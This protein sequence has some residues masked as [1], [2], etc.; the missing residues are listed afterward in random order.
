MNEKQFN[1]SAF[2]D[3]LCSNISHTAFHSSFHP[4][5]F[6]AVSD[7]NHMA[8]WKYVQSRVNPPFRRAAENPTAAAAAPDDNTVGEGGDAG[9]G[10]A[11]PRQTPWPPPEPN[12][13]VGLPCGVHPAQFAVKALYA[14]TLDRGAAGLAT[15]TSDAQ[16]GWVNMLKQGATM[17]MEMWTADEKP[18]L[19]WSHP[20]AS[21]L[22]YLVAWYLFGMQPTSPGMKTM[23]I[24]PAVGTLAHGRYVLPTV[25][26]RVTA[27]FTQTVGR[28]TLGVSLPPTIAADDRLP[29][30]IDI[31]AEGVVTA[32][33]AVNGQPPQRYVVEAGYVSVGTVS[34]GVHSFAISL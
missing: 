30:P 14:N 5:A 1:G 18:N 7:A 9:A 29:L 3:G 8:T 28:F 33:V 6:G 21:S 27:S 34:G 2:C 23:R 25:R 4:L 17:T 24:M 31:E 22:A 13:G 20:W 19:T 26:G 15:L 32:L 12:S 16:N 10:A 11:H